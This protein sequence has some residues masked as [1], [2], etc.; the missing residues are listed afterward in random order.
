MPAEIK[1]LFRPKKQI[2]VA[3]DGFVVRTDQPQEDGGDGSA[4]S[5]FDLFLASIGACAGFFIQAFCQKRGIDMTGLELTQQM[6][7]D[8]AS[9][10]VKQVRLDLRLPSAFP[11]KYREG[12]L[13]AANLCTVKRHLQQPPD[14]M[15]RI[16]PAV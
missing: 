10:L 7:W 4:P 2:E 5:P 11:E 15:I 16:V 8:E 6:E 3:C 13:S 1:I 12:I 9:H 14:V